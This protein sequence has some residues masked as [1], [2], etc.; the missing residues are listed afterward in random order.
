MGH[1]FRVQIKNTATPGCLFLYLFLSV[2]ISAEL[3]KTLTNVYK[4]RALD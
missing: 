3:L 4:I 1:K 2:K